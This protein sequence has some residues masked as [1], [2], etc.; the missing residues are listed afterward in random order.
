MTGKVEEGQGS[1][2]QLTQAAAEELRVAADEVHLIMADTTLV[3]DDGITAGS[4]TTP[5]TVPAVRRGAATARELLTRLAAEQWQVD[6]SAL[7]ADDGAITHKATKRTMTYAEL[8]AKKDVAGAFKQSIPSDVTIA[9]V[10]E[11]EVLGS[12]VPRPNNRD[13]V[14]G[15]HCFPSDVRR[16]NMLY[17]KILRA[18]SYGATLT[19]IDL[20]AA[21]AMKD[22]VVVREDQFV[23]CAAPTSY[24]A[25]QALKA[26]VKTASWQTVSHPSSKEIFSHLKKNARIGGRS[27]PRTRGSIDK[28]LAGASKALSET[29]EVAYIQHTPMEPRAATAE[30]KDGKLTV[31]TGIDWPQRAQR[32]LARAF[33]IPAEQIRVIVPDMGGGFGGKHSGEAAE[34]AARL[35]KA[36]GRPVAVHWTRAE[37]FTWAYFRPAALIEC[38]GGLDANGSLIAWDF[39][40]INA[41]GAAIDTPYNIPNTRILS[42]SSDSPLRQGPYRCLGA[43]ASNFARESFMDELAAAAGADPLAFRLAHLENERIRTV[44]ETVAK[45]FDWAARRK[46]VT[47]EVGVGLA[48]GTE[49]NSCV[50]ACAE[51]HIDRKRGEIKVREVCEAFEC[52][53]IQNPGNLVSQVHGCIIMGLGAALRE[54]MQFENG[55][56]LNAGFSGYLVPRFKDVPKIDVHLVNNTN[57][58]SAGGGETPIIAIAP[59]VGNAVFAATGIRIRSMPMRG[60]PPR[61]V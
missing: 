39:T 13:I 10:S 21:E 31:W 37:E 52:G 29:Y 24:C 35:A 8:A 43:T 22:V 55:K 59:A 20:S 12:S 41:G 2:A 9:P 19:S 47:A 51:V 17:G 56:I 26:I 14:T 30:W 11:W 28:G 5:S 48:C 15:E 4:R 45:R 7:D 33:Q 42:A 18:P 34:E 32:D 44:L 57:I 23:G 58:P 3:P 6:G 16:P 46:K 60:T 40:N 36:A 38:K 53:P 61:R 25:A 54:E 27:R 49:K 50:A 1:R